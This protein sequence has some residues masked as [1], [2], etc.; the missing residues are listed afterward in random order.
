MVRRINVCL[1]LAPQR[2][3]VP[4]PAMHNTALRQDA[5]YHKAVCF[6]P[7]HKR[8]NPVLKCSILRLNES[9]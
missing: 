6:V 5:L 4:S 8:E 2:P 1:P 7:C 9:R 3:M